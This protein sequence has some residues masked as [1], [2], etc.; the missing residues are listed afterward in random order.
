M[1]R[2]HYA[3]KEIIRTPRLG[4]VLYA[5]A[6]A[7]LKHGVPRYIRSDNGSKFVAVA[8]PDWFARISVQTLFI[9]PGS[10]REI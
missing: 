10:P 5:V 3:T 7:I 8:G 6:D 1:A 4:D 9:E 2:N